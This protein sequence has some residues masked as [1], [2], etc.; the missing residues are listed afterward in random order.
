VKERKADMNPTAEVVHHR[1]GEV[2]CRGSQEKAVVSDTSTTSE[3]SPANLEPV[4]YG[5]VA[6]DEAKQL[7][8][9]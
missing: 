4:L 8:R 7:G 9:R 3:R 5:D 2:T 1:E 6:R